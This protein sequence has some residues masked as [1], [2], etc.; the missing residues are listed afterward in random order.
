MFGDV[1]Q[2]LWCDL[3]VLYD[4]V[5]DYDVVVVGQ[6]IN[7]E[8]VMFW[9]IKFVYDEGVQWGMQCCGNFLC[10]WEVILG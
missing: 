9:G 10:D 3:Q 2:L 5:I 8:F 7:G 6:C 4:V 1:V